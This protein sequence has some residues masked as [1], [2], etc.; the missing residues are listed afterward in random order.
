MVTPVVELARGLGLEVRDPVPLRSTN[1]LVIWLRPS[2]VVAKVSAVDGGVAEEWAIARALSDRG[3]PI[4]A[5]LEGL[6]HRLHRVDDRD[7]TFWPY[8]SQD[9]ITEPSAQA[10]ARA[11]SDLHDALR[12]LHGHAVTRTFE[13][14]LSEPLA[15]LDRPDFSPE[16]GSQDRD[17][18]RAALSE[19]LTVLANRTDTGRTVHGSP[20]RGNILVVSGA[21]RFIDFETVRRGPIEW[22]LA[23]LPQAVADR[24]PG[25]FAPDVLAL[26]RTFVSATVSTWCWGGVTHGPDM[27]AHAEHHLTVVRSALLDPGSP[28]CVGGDGH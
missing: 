19:G 11:L 28:Q 3:A 20:H 17:L 9:R 26:C 21:P 10:V 22:D 2:S 14:H 12:T 7:V 13:D 15:A 25:I 4:V 1:N 24:Y 16:L 23:H 27:R 8:V 6:G 18:L 5:P